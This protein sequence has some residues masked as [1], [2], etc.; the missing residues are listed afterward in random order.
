DGSETLTHIAKYKSLSVSANMIFKSM[1]GSGI[2]STGGVK[3]YTGGQFPDTVYLAV[4]GS[5]VARTMVPQDKRSGAVPVT[6]TISPT[7]SS[8][9]F[10][11]DRLVVKSEKKEDPNKG[12]V[13]QLVFQGGVEG[14][15]FSNLIIVGI[16][17]PEWF[18]EF[19]GE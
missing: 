1:R 15:G 10:A 6:F 2:S 18:K 13:H 4:E 9:R 3:F 5:E 17:D 14:A 7:A 11:D 12:D 19:V 16:P 8:V